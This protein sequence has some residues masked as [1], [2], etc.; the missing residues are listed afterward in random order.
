MKLKTPPTT[1]VL[2]YMTIIGWLYRPTTTGV[3]D[4]QSTFKTE[5]SVK[6]AN[7]SS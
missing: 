3:L 5:N 7:K 4:N 2:K 6:E 1:V